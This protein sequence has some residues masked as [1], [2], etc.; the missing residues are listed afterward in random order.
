MTRIYVFFILM[1]SCGFLH[2]MKQ[3]ADTSWEQLYG[4][5]RSYAQCSLRAEE[6]NKKNELFAMPHEILDHIG[7]LLYNSDIDQVSSLRMHVKSL[8]ALRSTCKYFN[9]FL[10]CEY[11]GHVCAEYSSEVKEA[12]L[13]N[14]S[15]M[16]SYYLYWSKRFPMLTL[17]H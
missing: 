14:L 10:T 8:L 4:K 1:I 11:I 7:S 9:Q 3:R 15:H 17:V 6:Y 12:V 5:K 16:I 2:S 13:K